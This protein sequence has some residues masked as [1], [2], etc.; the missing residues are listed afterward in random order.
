MNTFLQQP[1]PSSKNSTEHQTLL[2][3]NPQESKKVN[4][5]SS[6]KLPNSDFDNANNSWS[7][8]NNPSLL[9]QQNAQVA[10]QHQ[11]QQQRQSNVTNQP[12]RGAF[13][14]ANKLSN[15]LPEQHQKLDSVKIKRNADNESGLRRDKIAA[16]TSRR[17][18]DGATPE[19]TST[20]KPRQYLINPLT[21]LLEPMPSDNSDS[22]IDNIVDN[23]DDLFSF[24]SPLNDRSNSV[25]SDDEDSNLSR[26]NDTTTDQS[27]SEA[28]VKSSA[29]ENSVKQS[30]IKSSG[31]SPVPGEKIKLR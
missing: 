17:G 11:Q 26:K 7:A 4:S 20:G 1:T 5:L 25:F 22:E 16:I 31:P 23:Q 18:N 6:T 12:S 8:R 2:R 30:R 24:S 28:T 15:H 19:Y 14:E 3:S 21:G 27:D 9:S 10:R 29:S 13:S